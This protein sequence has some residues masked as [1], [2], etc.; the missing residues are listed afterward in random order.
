MWIIIF[1]LKSC[2]K[3]F[4]IL[5]LELGF[6]SSILELWMLKPELSNTRADVQLKDIGNRWTVANGRMHPPPKMYKC[7]F[8]FECHLAK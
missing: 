5:R 4:K 1:N 8:V 7:N 6:N 3:N 2:V